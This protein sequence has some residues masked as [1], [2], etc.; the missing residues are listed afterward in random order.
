MPRCN[1]LA[2][3]LPVWLEPRARC[4]RACT[5]RS[6]TG[7]R[8]ICAFG[9]AGVLFLL[10][11]PSQCLRTAAPWPALT[12]LLALPSLRRCPS[13]PFRPPTSRWIT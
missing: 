5:D 2:L 9:G 11:R 12:R 6:G 1:G 4:I 3:S 13:P 10:L 7:T 8:P